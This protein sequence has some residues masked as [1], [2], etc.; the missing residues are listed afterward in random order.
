[1][2][3]NGSNTSPR[4]I[5]MNSFNISQKLRIQNR[6]EQ[7]ISQTQLPTFE[8]N[9]RQTAERIKQLNSSIKSNGENNKAKEKNS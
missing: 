7:F 4:N 9:N 8:K 3:S 1:M 6:R 2:S 5:Y